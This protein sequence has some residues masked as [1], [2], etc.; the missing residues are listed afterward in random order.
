MLFSV[1]DL[2]KFEKFEKSKISNKI[3]SGAWQLVGREK[4]INYI[5][6]NID[7]HIKN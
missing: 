6:N 3:L 7:K 5:K 2:K 1:Q 4:K